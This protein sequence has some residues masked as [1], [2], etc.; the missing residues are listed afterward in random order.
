MFRQSFVAAL[1]GAVLTVPACAQQPDMIKSINVETSLTDLNNPQAATYWKTLDNDLEAA[2]AANLVG[3]LGEDGKEIKIDM[4]EVEL[5]NFVQ[6]QTGAAETSMTGTVNVVDL[7]D[8]S[9]FQTFDLTVTMRQA[10]PMMPPGTD[11]L[12][13]APTSSQVYS[14]MVA[15][16]AKAVVDR[17]D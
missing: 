16:F 12:V 5:A 10:L 13:I 15:T 6:A 8:N 1:V 2:I 4:N 3:R 14:A 11:L 7:Q 9:N 17:I